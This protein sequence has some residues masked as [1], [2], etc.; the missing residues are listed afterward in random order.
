[1]DALPD[2]DRLDDIESQVLQRIRRRG[3]V[4]R[5]VATGLTVAALVVGAVVLVRPT[6][7]QTSG[8]SSGSGGDSAASAA[9]L[10][11]CHS[12]S[13]ARSRSRTVPLRGADTAKSAAAACALADTAR[14][15]GAT[16]APQGAGTAVV[17]RDAHGDFAVFP[18]DGH[19]ATLCARNGLDAA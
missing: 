10:V 7:G 16:S 6:V 3:E 8:A 11:H 15:S 5:R 14:A 12:T 13:A 1:M 9:V 19:P 17:C 18:A 4:R 2:Q